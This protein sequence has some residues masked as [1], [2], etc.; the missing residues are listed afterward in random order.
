MNDLNQNS[1]LH[2]L[3]D[4]FEAS[5]SPEELQADW[6]SMADKMGAT[7]PGAQ[8]DAG[9]SASSGTS[10]GFMASS[11]AKIVGVAAGI[12]SIGTLLFLAWPTSPDNNT[13]V[14]HSETVPQVVVS[15]ESVANGTT[16]NTLDASRRVAKETITLTE[17]PQKE[18][19]NSFDES[20]RSTPFTS[21]SG[22]ANI[23]TQ[24]PSNQQDEAQG[25]VEPT[26]IASDVT[27]QRPTDK[28]PADETRLNPTVIVA[29]TVFCASSAVSI[30]LENA[31]A[32]S[33]YTW[34]LQ[35]EKN[36]EIVDGG[37]LRSSVSKV[38]DRAGTYDLVVIELDNENE[39]SEILRKKVKVV[40]QP[41][42]LEVQSNQNPC[43]VFEFSGV[44]ENAT[45]YTW[46]ID[47]KTY[48]K[49]DLEVTFAEQGERQ[50]RFIAKNGACADTLTDRV[51][52]F[53]SNKE[54]KPELS[55]AITP[56]G[57]NRNDDFDIFKKNPDLRY[58]NPVLTIADRNGNLMFKSSE[59]AMVWN[60]SKMN[61]G[62]RCPSGNYFYV[63]TFDS[64]CS[65]TQTERMVG[66]IYLN[67]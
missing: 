52:F 17:A 12:A 7:D 50:V 24:A 41:K 67:R 15:E 55:N 25:A 45:Q 8:S 32:G 13:L 47:S 46:E 43:D 3:F 48:S 57:D 20:N 66:S 10:G 14:K 33:M 34:S 18:A 62:E 64:P 39:P 42:V 21:K 2:D 4:G 59:E 63:L 29:K 53:H 23:P 65:D 1:Q 37:S 28:D 22:V 9:S 31:K 60:G 11:A 38:I 49:K 16:N 30:K 36:K 61:V 44:A 19:D 58:R 51:D 56:N 27:G 54:S 35:N 26:S 40:A 5:Y 6:Q